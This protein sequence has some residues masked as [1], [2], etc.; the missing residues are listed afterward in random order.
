CF[1]E[2]DV[3]ASGMN[4]YAYGL[5][6]IFRDSFYYGDVR[7]EG[8]EESVASL[9]QSAQ[10]SYAAGDVY[11]KSNEVARADGICP[12]NTSGNNAVGNITAEGGKPSTSYGSNGDG[13]SFSGTV[14]SIYDGRT[15]SAG[16]PGAAQYF[17]EDRYDKIYI[18]DTIPENMYYDKVVGRAVYGQGGSVTD[19]DEWGQV[20]GEYERKE[21]N[22]L[23]SM[24]VS[25][26]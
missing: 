5:E 4:V 9:I 18:S 19:P 21:I 7:A 10:D 13:G 14:T 11:A 26:V 20:V 3:S 1:V 8:E 12:V 24:D 23:R 16:E 6:V 22:T 17:I 15:I 2:G 25:A